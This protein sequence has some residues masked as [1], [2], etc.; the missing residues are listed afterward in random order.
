MYPATI[1]RKPR[2]PNP[3]ALPYD[4]PGVL[5]NVSALVSLATIDS[6]TAHHGI[7]RSATK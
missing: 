2:F 5:M 6:I 3:G 4:R 7:A 1:W